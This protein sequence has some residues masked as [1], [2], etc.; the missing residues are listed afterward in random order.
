MVE[1]KVLMSKLPLKGIAGGELKWIRNYL[2]NRYQYAQYDGVKS[3]GELV[4]YGVP[5]GPILGPLLFLLQI[6]NLTKSVKSCN[7]HMYTDDTVIYTS[8]SNISNIEQTLTSEMTNVCKWLTKTMFIINLNKEKME[9]LL[10]GTAKCLCSKDLMEMYMNVNL[11]KVADGYKYL[12]VWLQPT[13]NMN[14]HL[15]SVLQK[16]NA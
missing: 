7:S 6:N 12:G 10:F 3:D 11:L 2:T 13:L 14:E 1:H 15:R 16:A 4:K 8:H 5:Q 9:L